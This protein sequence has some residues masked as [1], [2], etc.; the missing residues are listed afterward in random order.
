MEEINCMRGEEED[1]EEEED[2]SVEENKKAEKG[3]L[4]P[5]VYS[6]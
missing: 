3:N 5:E 2:D 1:E 4:N 6:N